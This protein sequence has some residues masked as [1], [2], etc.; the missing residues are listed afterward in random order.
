MAGLLDPNKSAAAPMAAPQPDAQSAQGQQ[1]AGAETLD[2]PILKQIETG[3]AQQVPADVKKMYDSIVLAGMKVMFSKETSDLM[4]QQLSAS[5]DVVTNVSDGVAKLIMIV[6]NQSGQQVDQFA[7]AAG[8]AAITL[9]CQALDYWE[10]A[11][12]G[13]VT[14]E[15]AAQA[16]QATMQKVLESFGITQDQVGQVIAAGEQAGAQGGA[17]PQQPMGA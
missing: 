8:L 1:G 2:D 10:Q 14:E 15:L 9:M 16:T 17:Q 11:M 5:D 3:I 12:G 13:E 7:P 4:E 6:Y